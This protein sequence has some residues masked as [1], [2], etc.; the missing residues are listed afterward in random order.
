M[1]RLTLGDLPAC[2]D[3]AAD[4]GWVRR[5]H[6]WRLLLT[7][8]QG[9]GIDA[10][11]DDSSP[12]AAPGA[13]GA[14]EPPGPPEP[15]EPADRVRRK[16]IGVCVLTPYG[17]PPHVPRGRPSASVSMVLVA[18]RHARRGLGRLL[19]RHALAEAGDATV[20]LTAND[21]GRP[22][23]EKL[24]F[25]AVGTV[26]RLTGEFTG[27][28]AAD[29]RAGPRPDLRV[30]DAT[31]ADL[32]A[33]LAL[34]APVFGADRTHLIVRLPSLA[35]RFAVAAPG[36][37]GAELTGYAARWPGGDAA[38][39]GPVVA[40]DESTARALITELAAHAGGP[41]RI[42][43]DARHSGLRSWLRD[44]GLTERTAHTLMVHGAPDLPGDPGRRF[45]PY[46]GSLG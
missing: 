3:L 24:G 9:Y 18:G 39:I 11:A 35:D 7:A 14:P 36:A 34:D 1:R 33:V 23:Y 32:P 43:A 44:R 5:E 17:P 42:D 2:L 8:G 38:V 40:E 15:S 13:P 6:K 10:P 30:R 4:R 16:L 26:V 21:S 45:A 20:F 12:P 28:H 41:V 19:V 29:H 31:A 25:T 22:L 27:A 46:L 37:P